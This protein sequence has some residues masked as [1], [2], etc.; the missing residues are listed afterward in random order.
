[1]EDQINNLC[2][3]LRDHNRDN[4]DE[5]SKVIRNATIG[6]I[7][8]HIL[9]LKNTP[10][11][12]RKR[13]ISSMC[14]LKMIGKALFYFVS[15][16]CS[17]LF[18]HSFILL[19]FGVTPHLTAYTCS[20]LV[21]HNYAQFD[22]ISTPSIM[23][24]M[25]CLGLSYRTIKRN[26][27]L[28]SN[29]DRL[30]N[31]TLTFPRAIAMVYDDTRTTMYE[32]YQGKRHIASTQLYQDISF[33]EGYIQWAIESIWYT[34]THSATDS[35]RTFITWLNKK[36]QIIVALRD[37]FIELPII[38]HVRKAVNAIE[39]TVDRHFIRPFR[40]TIQ[41]GVQCVVD[42][43]SYFGKRLIQWGKTYKIG[44]ESTKIEMNT[45]T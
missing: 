25:S 7:Q 42:G 40:E 30:Q 35:T 9:T 23:K 44:K 10:V 3:Q 32:L 18:I 1:M 17:F 15:L 33:I 14:T 24:A 39:Y 20:S 6:L 29:I 31:Y 37:A 2:L 28:I 12:C 22:F 41:E 43:F 36:T 16:S 11:K 4:Q 38:R 34:F 27:E 26:Q 13:S 8:D 21:T 19:Y 5:V 45:S